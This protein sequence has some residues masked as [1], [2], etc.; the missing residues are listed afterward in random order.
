MKIIKKF[1]TKIKS[2]K[3]ADRNRVN[4]RKYHSFNALIIFLF[5]ADGRKCSSENCSFR[6]WCHRFSYHRAIR[7]LESPAE[8]RRKNSL[9]ARTTKWVRTDFWCSLHRTE[10]TPRWPVSSVF[11]K[12]SIAHLASVWSI[13]CWPRWL[14]EWLAARA[15]RANSISATSYHFKWHKRN[16]GR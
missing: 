9:R 14:L 6:F 7:W 16:Y 3:A 2:T 5:A 12:I 1:K 8:F 13:R 11:G 4:R 15:W 10:L